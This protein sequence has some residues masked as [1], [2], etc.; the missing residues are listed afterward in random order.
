MKGPRGRDYA[1][2]E[3]QSHDLQAV[4]NY[5]DKVNEAIMILEANID[6]LT[7][8]RKYYEGLLN[9]KHFPMKRNCSEDVLRFANQ[10]NNMIGN[11]KMQISRA[12]LLVRITSDRKSLVGNSLVATCLHFNWDTDVNIGLATSPE[13]NNRENGSSDRKDARRGGTGT[14]RGHLHPNYNCSYIVVPSC[15]LC[16]GMYLKS[17]PFLAPKLTEFPKTFFS[18]DVVKYQNQG[19]GGPAVFGDN[20]SNGSFSEVALLRWLE[21]ALPLTAITMAVVAYYFRREKKRLSSIFSAGF[22]RTHSVRRVATSLS[23]HREC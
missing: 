9:H 2:Y 23:L 14:E 3:Y 8:L 22:K 16:V 11:S 18:T 13:S 19:T 6:V 5:E 7:A 17:F 10:V 21:V 12:K 4:Q 15:N 20:T 1:R